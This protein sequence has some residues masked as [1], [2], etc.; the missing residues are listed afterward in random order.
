MEIRSEND[1]GGGIS[2]GGVAENEVKTW[3]MLTG[4]ALYMIT[5]LEKIRGNGRYHYE[6]LLCL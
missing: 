5:I 6:W 3:N 1:L 4:I 2:N